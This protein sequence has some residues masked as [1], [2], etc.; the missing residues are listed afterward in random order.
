MQ[1]GTIHKFYQDLRTVKI[2]VNRV[3]AEAIRLEEKVNIED[4]NESENLPKE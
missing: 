4:I 2:E 3:I 1:L